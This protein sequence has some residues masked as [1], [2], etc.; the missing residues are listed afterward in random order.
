MPKQGGDPL[1]SG[2]VADRGGHR[3]HGRSRETRD[4]AGQRSLHARHHDDGVGGGQLV[5]GVED[6]VESGHTDVI[7]ADRYHAVGG[8]R[9]HALVGDREVSGAG[10]HDRDPFR[11]LRRGTPA[12]GVEPTPAGVAAPCFDDAAP[13]VGGLGGGDLLGI[14]AR[15]HDRRGARSGQQL[16]HDGGAL[17]RGL[18]GPED[19]LGH[20]LA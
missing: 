15:E 12:H 7:D 2:A 11:A 1:E 3:H 10:G 9:G 20:A 4:H 17:A 5:G 6:A 18:A 16:G 19:G 8:E 13:G 14:S